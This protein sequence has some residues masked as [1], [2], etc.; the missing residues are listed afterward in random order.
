MKKALFLLLLMVLLLMGCQ[1]TPAA[2]ALEPTFFPTAEPTPA[3][4]VTL[5]PIQELTITTPPPTPTPSPT[6]TASPSPTPSPTPE[7]TPTAT[8]EPTPFTVVWMPD[9]QILSRYYPEIFNTMRDW[10]LDNREKENIQ[11][12]IHTG[13]VV[14]GIGPAMFETADAAMTPIFEAIPGMVVS[15]NHDVTGTG[16]Q[17]YFLQRP[18]AKLVQKEGQS[19]SNGTNIYASYVTFRAAGTD[20]LVFGICYDVVCTAWMNEVIAKYPDH[21]VITV[22]HKGLQ[23]TGEYS[24]EGR[25]I[26]L[27][28]MPRWPNFRLLFCGHMRGT[29]T[30]TEWFDDDMDGNAERSVTTMLFNYQDDRTNGL[31]FIRLLRFDPLTRS[32]EVRTY[33][34][35]F[36]RWG[37]SRAKD[38]D[39]H[40][41]LINA[42]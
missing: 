36:D 12:V 42:W 6:P 40:F 5:P 7:P 1:G 35:W 20:F 25:A 30:R 18:Y 41:T 10:I 34:P 9:T 4:P 17:Y 26:F 39:N 14:D 21:V 38:E 19:Y 3:P 24:K 23:E 33:S 15:G 32:I 37:Y 11:F 28:V 13:D 16:S 8:P 22:L 27:N 2:D 29:M 31:G